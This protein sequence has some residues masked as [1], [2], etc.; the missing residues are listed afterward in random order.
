V[1]ITNP[2]PLLEVRHAQLELT[3]RLN[4]L[5]RGK[6]RDMGQGWTWPCFEC[7]R[8]ARYQVS[9]LA[10]DLPPRLFLGAPVACEAHADHARKVARDRGYQ[11]EEIRLEELPSGSMAV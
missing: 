5:G 1:S 6:G 8:P 9:V 11:D 4:G 7:N 10:T 3:L 2:P